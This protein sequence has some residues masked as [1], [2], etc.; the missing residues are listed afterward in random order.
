M[1]AIPRLETE[2]TVLSAIHPKQAESVFQIYSD[3]LVTQYSE[4]DSF[5]DLRQANDLI[6]KFTFW[7]QHDQG[8]RWGVYLKSTEQ[9]IGIC[10]FDTYL[11]KFR[12]ANLG[13]DF[14]SAHWGSGYATEAVSEIL[15]YAFEFGLGFKIN[16]LSAMT[17]PENVASE[18][19]LSKI[20]FSKEGQM[21]KFGF[22]DNQ[23]HDMNLFSRLKD[24]E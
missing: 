13:Y 15:D 19:V 22:W 4:L 14:A 24:D 12:S 21:R 1:Q 17:H 20:G 18:R 10:C 5:A 3:P 11:S 6:N 9:L 23:Y 2:R 8:V 16:R 7:F